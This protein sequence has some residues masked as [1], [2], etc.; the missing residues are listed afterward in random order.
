MN[1]TTDHVRR[2]VSQT[3]KIGPFSLKRSFHQCEKREQPRL[4]LSHVEEIFGSAGDG[5]HRLV[6]R[7]VISQQHTILGTAKRRGWTRAFTYMRFMKWCVLPATSILPRVEASR[8]RTSCGPPGTFPERRS[9]QVLDGERD[10]KAK[11]PHI[12]VLATRAA[13]APQGIRRRRPNG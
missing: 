10:N 9:V 11:V 1:G 5:R 12:Y 8:C 7:S 2:R 13:G 4:S 6:I 3:F